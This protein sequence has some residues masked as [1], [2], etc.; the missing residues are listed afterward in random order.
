[1][2]GVPGEGTFDA[3]TGDIGESHGFGRAALAIK[4]Q[5]GKIHQAALKVQRAGGDGMTKVL[6]KIAGDVFQPGDVG[7]GQRPGQPA[8]ILADNLIER[9]GNA[10]EMKGE[11]VV[12]VMTV[13]DPG[14]GAFGGKHPKR[15]L[16]Q[17][18]A[19]PILENQAAAAINHGIKFPIG[20]RIAAHAVF[21][22]NTTIGEVAEHAM[23]GLPKG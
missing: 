2:V 17:G 10:A 18:P 7:L 11:P 14:V 8:A 21:P 12:S 15:V 13:V 20:A 22:A 1:M 3:E 16:L 6:F 19:R 9:V 23:E 4:Q 5:Q